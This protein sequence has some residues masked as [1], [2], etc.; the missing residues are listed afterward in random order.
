MKMDKFQIIID[1]DLKTIIPRYIEILW[2]QLSLL[3]QAIESNDSETARMLGHKLK[4]T[5][6]SYG[7]NRL[8]ELGAAIETAS[9]ISDF[10][11]TG[12]LAT[13]IRSYLENVEI[14]YG[15]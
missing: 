14:V 5:G 7:F 8:T 12:V 11:T 10:N 9:K 13:E 3:D 2:E 6:S 4:G 1:P 15:K